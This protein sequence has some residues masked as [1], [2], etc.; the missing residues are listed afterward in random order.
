MKQPS[1]DAPIPI[2]GFCPAC[3]SRLVEQVV[4]H[5]ERRA[6]PACGRIHWRNAKPCAGALVLRHG[7]VLL[8]RRT[9]EPF[10]GHWDIPGGFCEVNE[11]P[12]ETAIR[13][14]LEETGLEIELTGLLGLWLDEYGESVTLNIYYFA[15]PLTRR[16]R[17]GDDADGA[18]WF[19]PDALPR[20]IAFVNGRQALASWGA[21]DRTPLHLRGTR[22][23]ASSHAT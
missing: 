5:R 8:I 12:T 11:H 6:C 23:A 21:G 16:L 2:L 19:A 18:A 17:V 13:E 15:R 14:V 1:L 7:K 3:G 22:A 20:R 9:I 10:L 4:D